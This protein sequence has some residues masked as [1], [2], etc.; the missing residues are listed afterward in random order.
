MSLGVE[1]Q[2]IEF[3]Y[4]D[5]IELL[6]DIMSF[7]QYFM[8]QRDKELREFLEKEG[9]KERYLNFLNLVDWSENQPEGTGFQVK[10]VH[11]DVSFY[12]KLLEETNPKKSLLM[13]MTLIYLFAIFE[14]F[15]K[16][17]FFK[18]Y[19]SKPDLMKSDQKQISYRKALDFTSLEELHKTI[20]EREVDKIGRND[21]DEL[22]KM[23]K[24]KFSID[25]EQDFKHWN[26]LREKYYRRNIVVHYNGKISEA[27]LKKMNLPA[28]K[29]N[30][31]LDIDPGYVHFC[32]YSIGTYLN[33]V[34]NKIKDKFNLNISR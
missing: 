23:L 12:H 25:L 14:A 20:A 17:F 33:F 13:K 11:M 21:V 6:T 27:Y 34:F 9:V 32:S 5:Q 29:L 2:D 4:Q 8:E 10:T 24:N 1:L 31:E 18:L 19:I 30:Q 15:N 16:D 28:E 7:T 3:K 22:T 26:V